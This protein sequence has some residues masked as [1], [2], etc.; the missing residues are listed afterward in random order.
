MKLLWLVVVSAVALAGCAGEDSLTLDE[1]ADQITTISALYVEESQSLSLRY[2]RD[3]E[4]KVGELTNA[5][6]VALVTA[7][8]ILVSGE[9]ASYLALL[10]DAIN[11]YVVSM[12]ELNPP[13][14][15]VDGHASYVEV[16]SSVHQS[17]PAM[18]DAVASS[19]SMTDIQLAL[20]GSGFADGQAVW[21]AACVSLEQDIR[22]LG[23]G[24]DLKC[25]KPAVAP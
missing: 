7:A 21:T 11:R 10:D 23:R 25:V 6:G 9:T 2:Q 18:R 8:V 3:V 16:V 4:R 14:E 20:A 22:D 24:A 5:G 19:Q 13:S 12:S 17:L 1:Y 15:L